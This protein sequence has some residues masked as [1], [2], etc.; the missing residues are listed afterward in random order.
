MECELIKVID[1]YGIYKDAVY[2]I[3]YC[4]KSNKLAPFVN[5]INLFFSLEDNTAS[6]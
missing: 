2:V 4:K 1:N 6:I 5:M 3:N